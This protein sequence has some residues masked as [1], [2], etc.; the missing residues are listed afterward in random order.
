MN[1]PHGYKQT[2]IRSMIFLEGGALGGGAV[3]AL[4]GWHLVHWLCWAAGAGVFWGYIQLIAH[5]RTF[6]LSV[7]CGVALSG[8]AGYWLGY[9]INNSQVMGWAI[10]FAAVI[11]SVQ[12]K[13]DFRDMVGRGLGED[14][15]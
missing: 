14:M 15:P 7:L 3:I 10:G 5:R 4:W 11:Y 1:E 6:W 9:L 2:L 13:L 8:T 12:S